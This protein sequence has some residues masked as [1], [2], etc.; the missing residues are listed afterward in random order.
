MPPT[1]LFR[2][3]REH[4]LQEFQAKG[5]DNEQVTSSYDLTL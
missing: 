4:S 3:L 1:G 2:L 5:S